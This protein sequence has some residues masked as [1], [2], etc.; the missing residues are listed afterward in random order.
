MRRL[1][2][3]MVTPQRRR[4]IDHKSILWLYGNVKRTRGASN[5]QQDC[6]END[7]TEKGK[8]DY[9]QNDSDIKRAWAIQEFDAVCARSQQNRAKNDI[10]AG[11]GGGR[12]VNQSYP[13]GVPRVR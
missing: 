4:S 8:P 5:A 12:A 2:K 10:G 9:R 13:T 11:N 3:F 1:M 7:D 6:Y